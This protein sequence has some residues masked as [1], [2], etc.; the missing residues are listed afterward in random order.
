ML[1]LWRPELE[2]L[3]RDELKIRALGLFRKQMKYVIDK[4]PFYKRKFKEAGV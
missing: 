1:K 4:S 2:T 3:P